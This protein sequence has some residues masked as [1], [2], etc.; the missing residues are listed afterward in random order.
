[1][2]AALSVAFRRYF[3]MF[4]AILVTGIILI[5]TSNGF[6]EATAIYLDCLMGLAALMS[7][8]LLAVPQPPSSDP[9]GDGRGSVRRT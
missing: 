2:L 5:M 3:V 6:T 9:R 4:V 1:M 7:D 8:Y